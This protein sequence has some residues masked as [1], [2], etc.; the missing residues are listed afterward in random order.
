MRLDTQNSSGCYFTIICGF[1]ATFI[2]GI[3]WYDKG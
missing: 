3:T 2:A 1:N